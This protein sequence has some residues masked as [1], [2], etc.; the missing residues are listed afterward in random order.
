MPTALP[1]SPTPP[2]E[3]ALT[4]TCVGLPSDAAGA[5]L[6]VGRFESPVGPLIVMGSG[7][8]LWGLGLAAEIGEDAVRA[9]LARRWPGTRLVE[10]PEAMA[11]IVGALLRGRGE[12]R[13]RLVGT[14][15]QTRIWRALLEVPS[16]AVIGYGA[17]A[18]RIGN[19][20]AARA[21]GR[22][23]GQNPVAWI[24]PCHRVARESGAEGGYHWG[25]TVKRALQARERAEG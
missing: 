11:P 19:P 3:P 14:A 17:L 20:G 25:L 5:T 1:R 15:F 21:A 23:V 4:V 2:E 13:V 24:V 16:G 22:A 6:C 8:T 12:I 18:A 9:D 10:A 7:G